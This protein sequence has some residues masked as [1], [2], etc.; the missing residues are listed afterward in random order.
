MRQI[1]NVEQAIGEQLHTPALSITV[2]NYNYGHFLPN[3]LDSILSQDF[4]DFEVILINDKSTDNS[5]EIIAPYLKDPRIRLIDHQ[6]NKGFVASLIEGV[7]LSRGRYITVIS[8]DDW[9]LK[10]DA[11]LKQMAILEREPAVAFVYTAYGHYDPAH[12]QHFIWRSGSSSF[13]RPGRLVFRELVL[14]PFILHSGTVI[15]RSAYDAAGGYDPTFRYSVDTKLWLSLCHYGKVAYINEV[16]YAYCRH[17]NNMS[18]SA[19]SLRR[20]IEEILKA[21]DWSFGLLPAPERVELA[22]LKA[23][24]ERR[25]LVAFVVD[26]VFGSNYKGGWYCYWVALKFHPL[27]TLLQRT[28]LI[29]VLRTLLGK[30]GFTML[31]MLKAR[32]SSHTRQR[33]AISS[34]VESIS[35]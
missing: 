26:D 33:L 19:V 25:A 13:I 12:K 17:G 27:K 35:E 5:L 21:V 22:N 15:R 4:K 31:E 18:K 34:E 16:L 32:F 9:I 14:S 29:L 2:L 23:Q 20:A 24:V 3:C 11:L 30:R 8:A 6:I 28:T 1:L 10:S 7:E